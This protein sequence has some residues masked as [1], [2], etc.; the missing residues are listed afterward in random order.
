MFRR[1]RVTVPP[2][3]GPKSVQRTANT[4][5]AAV[6]AM[7]VHHCCRNVTRELSMSF[8]RGMAEAAFYCARRTEVGS[9]GLSR[10]SGLSG[11]SDRKF[12][13]KNQIDQKDHPTR[14]TSPCALREHRR[15]TGHPPLPSFSF[16]QPYP[17]GA[18]S[19]GP[20]LRAS[21]E[22]SFIVRVLRARRTA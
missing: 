17:R 12:I 6:E 18:Q 20:S 10:L 4:T 14:Q 8:F 1:I 15:P 21:D 16:P 5:R 7:T 19:D 11:W 9:S 13:Q 3:R 2:Y 22:H